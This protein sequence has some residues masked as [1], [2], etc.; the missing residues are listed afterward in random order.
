MRTMKIDVIRRGVLF[1]A[2]LML[3]SGLYAQQN[4]G[5]EERA[6]LVTTLQK[7]ADPV[8]NNLS[9]NTLKINMPVESN[10][11]EREQYTYLE[12]FGRLVAGMAPWLALGADSTEEG[13]LRAHYISLIQ[14]SLDN[15]TNPGAADYM[16]F[17]K[18]AQPLVDAAFLAQGLLRA[19]VELWDPLSDQV[20]QN[21]IQAFKATR[22]IKP[23]ESNWLLFSAMVEA[24]LLKFDGACNREAI[25]YAITKHERWYKGDGVYGDG[26]NFHWDYYNSF[27]IQPML[28]E[29]VQQIRN[30]EDWGIQL[31]D[32][33]FTL[34]NNRAARYAAIQERMISPEGTYPVIGRSM[35]Y[36]FGA[37]QNLAK[38]T[39]EGRL[40]KGIDPRQVRSALYTVIKRQIEA[41]ETF[42]ENG[43]L[44]VGF[45]GHQPSIGEPYISTGS[46]YLCSEAFLIL[47]IPAEDSFWNGPDMDWTSRKVW[48]GVDINADHRISN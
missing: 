17:D 8:L 34:Y 15:A 13:E 12:A 20:K 2:Y 1:I 38:M 36:R 4:Q 39:L 6:Y 7:I 42:D 47:G 11:K 43:W 19:P 37:F 44:R 14:K 16:N 28:L 25:E 35:A 41:P 24:A 23:N 29:V 21:I 18:G 40:P 22:V 32:S 45:Y 30:R 26:P 10:G 3:A 33:L 27:V 9:A 5:E 48:K 31:V 46:L